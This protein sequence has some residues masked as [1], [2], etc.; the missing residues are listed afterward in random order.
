MIGV[1]RQQHRLP[2]YSGHMSTAASIYADA[3]PAE[4]VREAYA[5]CLAGSA[6]EEIADRFNTGGAAHPSTWTPASLRRK[7][8]PPGESKR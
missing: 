7:L 3:T 5:L 1:S 6:P 4:I 2:D 8:T